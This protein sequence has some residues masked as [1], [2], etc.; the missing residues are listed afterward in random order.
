M[1][2]TQL[3]EEGC[4]RSAGAGKVSQHSDMFTAL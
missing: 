3:F 1:C 4:E 2:K